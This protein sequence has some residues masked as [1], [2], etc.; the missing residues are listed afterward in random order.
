MS[1]EPIHTKRPTKDALLGDEPF[2]A[3]S[4]AIEQA[5]GFYERD[6]GRKPSV[7]ELNGLARFWDR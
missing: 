5:V 7:L 3:I 4:E 2:D 6:L 1:W